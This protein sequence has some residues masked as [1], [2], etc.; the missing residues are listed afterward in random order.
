MVSP[1]EAAAA[2]VDPVPRRADLGTTDGQ[3]LPPPPAPPAGPSLVAGGLGEAFELWSRGTYSLGPGAPNSL[4]N[5]FIHLLFICGESL[6]TPK[7]RPRVPL[8]LL[9]LHKLA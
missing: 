6:R 9:F 1:M 2:E 4:P 8:Q 5:P 3:A 7:H